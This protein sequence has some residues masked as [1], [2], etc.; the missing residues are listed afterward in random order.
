[1]PRDRGGSLGR[2]D[3]PGLPEGGAA[4]RGCPPGVPG[5]ATALR[6]RLRDYERRTGRAVSRQRLAGQL[7]VSVR[8]VYA[9]LSGTTLIPDE[10]LGRLLGLLGV[11]GP[12]ADSLRRARDQVEEARR[13]PSGPVARELPPAVAAFTGRAGQ[14]AE[15]DQLR[16]ARRPAGTA[17]VCVLA[18]MAG[19]GKTALAVAWAHGARARFPDGCLFID[20]RGYDLDEPLDPF[21]AL[22][23]LLRSLGLTDAELPAG[24]AARISRYRM[25][26][27]GRRM[28][29]V[30]D[31][32]FSAEQVRPLLPAAAGCFVL[33][34]SRDDLA[35]L[36]AREGAQRIT[37]GPL[38]SVEGLALLTALLGRRRVQAGQQAA[39]ALAEACAGLPLALR[40]TAE[41]TAARP[42]EPL[43]AIAEEIRQRRLAMLAAA[44][45]QRA[46][47]RAVLSWSYRRLTADHPDAAQAFRLLGAHPGQDFDAR[48]A[49]ALW[50]TTPARAAALIDILAR[51]HLAERRPGTPPRFGLHGLLRAYAAELCAANDDGNDPGTALDRLAGYY[52]FTAR[53]AAR[54]L[55]PPGPE[56]PP[57]ADRTGLVLPAFDGAGSARCWLD[58][59]RHNLVAVAV[60]AA[61]HRL[62]GHASRL[63]AVL[64]P[65]LDTAGYYHDALTVHGCALHD[66]DAAA[67]GSTQA[68]LATAC[69]R[70]G[71]LQDALAHA[72]QALS[73]ARAAGEL[74]TQAA[75]HLR[76]GA[77]YSNL[78]QNE[79]AHKHG[80]IA[81]ELARQAGDRLAEGRITGN[82]AIMAAQQHRYGEAL[83]YGLRALALARE[84]GDRPGE[85]RALCNIGDI[86]RLAGRY[87]EATAYGQKAQVIAADIGDRSAQATIAANLAAT[88]MQLGRYPEAQR[89][90]RQAITRARDIGNRDLET[91]ARSGLENAA[92]WQQSRP[93]GAGTAELCRPVQDPL[94]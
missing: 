82:L 81:R 33:V 35:G 7:N 37:V 67:Q 61:G 2:A 77:V 63:S 56:N 16:A 48:S 26:A 57:A 12:E 86:C 66:P 31:N 21:D 4:A 50:G 14:L 76:L 87:P 83:E 30:L 42:T 3:S 36:V 51:S 49:A 46:D 88:C 72:R 60:A 8:S 70:L 20:L 59:E 68:S 79:T 29:I 53:E 58:A 90:F 41:A 24:L 65:Y 80:Q 89:Y 71:R 54:R 45:D 78:G 11:P 62:Y 92:C 17:A 23:D 74:G 15:L 34:T 94:A 43:A 47:L 55:A 64:A 1:M 28:L 73:L 93:G 22:G 27:D 40:L 10:V 38:S 18:G 19:V 6:D 69:F 91:R 52:T 39:Q 5:L 44:G 84:L 85:G 32:A 13:R 75:A 9:Y 25:L